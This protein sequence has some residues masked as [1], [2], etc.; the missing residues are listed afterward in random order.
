MTFANASSPAHGICH[1]SD[2]GLLGTL[3]FSLVLQCV[4]LLPS[5][6]EHRVAALIAETLLESLWL[7]VLPWSSE[8]VLLLSG[9]LHFISSMLCQ[10]AGRASRTLHSQ[11]CLFPLLPDTFWWWLEFH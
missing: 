2:P 11:L 9:W 4:C 10:L 8:V 7:P 5:G 1:V 3:T 6:K